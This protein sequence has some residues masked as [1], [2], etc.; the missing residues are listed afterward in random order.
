MRLLTHHVPCAE[1]KSLYNEN[2]SLNNSKLNKYPY[3]PVR[4]GCG[5]C[6]VKSRSKYNAISLFQYIYVL[7]VVFQ[8]YWLQCYIAISWQMTIL[9]STQSQ[10]GA[11]YDLPILANYAESKLRYKFHLFLLC[12]MYY[13]GWNRYIPKVDLIA[14]QWTRLIG[15]TNIPQCA[16]L[17]Q[18]CA[19]MCT[20]LLQGGILGL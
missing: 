2:W 14:I 8:W 12:C 20:F 11:P 19:H 18:R 16:V 4:A 10:S 6:I 9:S 17:W 3:N 13:I 5:V 15:L 7:I 1:F